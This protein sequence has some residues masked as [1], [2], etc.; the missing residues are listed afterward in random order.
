[1][2]FVLFSIIYLSIRSDF[3]ENDFENRLTVLTEWVKR[4]NAISPTPDCLAYV[5]HVNKNVFTLTYF[6]TDTLR[7]IK[8]TKHDDT[9][10]IFNF[11]NQQLVRLAGD[12]NEARVR[13]HE[14]DSHKFMARGDD[15][16]MEI[17]CPHDERFDASQLRCV[18]VPPC[19]YR[20]PGLYGLDERMIDTL[21]LNHRV[22]REPGDT[23]DV[24]AYHPTLYLRCMLGGSHVIE[25]CPDNHIFNPITN[26]CELRNDCANRPDGYQLSVFPE[27]LSINQYMICQ[28]GEPTVATCPE[29]MVF[30]RRL[31]SCVNAHPCMF[32]GA[33]Y[34]YITDDIRDNQFY[35]CVSNVDS[36][37][38]TCIN[39]V[40]VDGQY[41]CGGDA[42][43]QIF[44]NGTGQQI[45]A[46][47]GDVIEY[48][49]GVLTCDGYAVV[50][51]VTCDTTD[52]LDNKRFNDEKFEV[53][54]RLP[55]EV[56]DAAAGQCVPF[57]MQRVRVNKP[58]YSISNQN[59]Y[60]VNFETA[61]VGVTDK[62][63]SLLETE[64][65]DDLVEYA[66]D[67]NVL[68]IDADTNEPIHCGAT[69]IFNDIFYGREVNECVDG[70]SVDATYTALIGD[71]FYMPRVDMLG[72][73]PDYDQQCAD[74]MSK[75]SNY[76]DLDRFVTR[77]LANILQTDV[78]TQMFDLIA[79]KYTTVNRKYTTIDLVG[80]QSAE[81][82]SVD[83][84]GYGSNTPKISSTILENRPQVSIDVD[85]SYDEDTIMPAFDPFQR[86]VEEPAA[87]LPTSEPNDPPI[88]P[89]RPPTPDE[90]DEEK[91]EEEE[92]PVV[93]TDKTVEF[94]CFYSM[95]VFKMTACH[96]DDARVRDA[97]HDLRSNVE[98]H[99]DCANA[100]G[101]SHMINAYAY[102]GDGIGCRSV[103]TPEN[104]IRVERVA[105]PQ[106]FMN[107]DTQSNDGIKYNDW[108]H[109]FGDQYTACPPDLLDESH[110][111]V[112]DF[113]R[114]YYVHDLH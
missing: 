67:R 13:P 4:N 100:A 43:C 64:R 55:V 30:D 76:V 29:G 77:I 61:F 112:V 58:V 86:R 103:L 72:S 85:V 48:D 88:D 25:E 75:T 90:E 21:V 59:D 106:V 18:P 17:A 113:N 23:E 71:Q 83:I 74:Q 96:V 20:S 108:V 35:R 44:D 102:I 98:V 6:H 2:A 97:L 81:I 40:F 65:L 105:E 89:P 82:D 99:T 26:A 110:N 73:D 15:G 114:L 24:T 111:C 93:M 12:G 57:D 7:V 50:A 45:L 92:P 34:T 42:R 31:M 9:E 53:N 80:T 62:A 68:G 91:E 104:G 19:Q 52:M 66:R 78:C 36:E 46:T 11:V 94:G 54:I 49:Y 14:N 101:L 95:P 5:S 56:F 10:E 37:L 109:K 70:E 27:S 3:N 87:L 51:D 79:D 16:W 47:S 41:E 32:Q 69:N 107:L 60:E 38:I 1:M 8:T 28:G 63:E 22:Y 39:R 84:E 33:G